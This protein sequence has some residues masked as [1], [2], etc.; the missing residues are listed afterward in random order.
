MKKIDSIEKKLYQMIIARLSG[1]LIDKPSYQK[2]IFDLI[3]K[4]IGGFILF[5]GNKK[6]IKNFIKRLQDASEIPLFIASDIEKGVGQQVSGC[7]LFPCQMAV[8]TAIS[9]NNKSDEKLLESM[10]SAI[11]NEA[12]DIGINMPLIPVVDVN[13]NPDNPIICTRS[14]SDNPKIVSW[15]SRRYIRMMEKSGLITCAKHFPGHGDTS[16]DSHLTLPIVNKSLKELLDVDIKPFQSAINAGV[17]SIML[18]HLCILSVDD[19]PSSI[20]EKIIKN[21]LRKKLKFKKLI[22]TDALT[23]KALKDIKDV[24]FQCIKAGNDILLHPYNPSDSV[25]LLMKKLINKELKEERI[26]ESIDR[27]LKLKSKFVKRPSYKIDYQKNKTISYSITKKSIVLIKN[28]SDLVPIKNNTKV[29][30]SIFGEKDLFDNSVFR[31]VFTNFSLIDFN[32]ALKYKDSERRDDI[33]M[34]L[35]FSTVAAWKGDAGLYDSEIHD[36]KRLLHKFKKSIIISFGNPYVV[37][38]FINANS[39][40]ISCDTDQPAQKAAFECV[41][42]RSRFE[43]C[44]PINL[45]NQDIIFSPLIYPLSLL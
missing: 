29:F 34:S 39:I 35:I 1:D 43:G 19:K 28:E 12:L 13:Q 4:G 42:G 16:Q 18:G 38:Y 25:R 6:G 45:S 2:E 44:L 30:L 10:L 14:F 36:V 3:E 31:K 5:G 11:I 8:A 41:I 22:I 20:S 27:I 23:M 24:E 40:I 15:F 37:R 32:E 9:R 7:T 17:S 21:L 33:L 26:D